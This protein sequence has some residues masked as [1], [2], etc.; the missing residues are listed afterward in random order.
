[1]GQLSTKFDFLVNLF[2][3]NP[4]AFNEHREEVIEEFISTLPPDRADKMRKFQLAVDDEM[5]TLPPEE[6]MARLS[7]LME[8]RAVV[9]QQSIDK[10]KALVK[11]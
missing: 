7:E 9:F 10:L 6:R 3:T 11:K 4:A 1:M 2:K 8:E 5:N